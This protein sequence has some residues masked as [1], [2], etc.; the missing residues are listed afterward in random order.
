MRGFC[1]IVNEA[2]YSFHF[3][4]RHEFQVCILS[5]LHFKELS[6]ILTLCLMKHCWCI[7]TQK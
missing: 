5:A 2:L 4:G 7:F 6:A 1:C 3:D